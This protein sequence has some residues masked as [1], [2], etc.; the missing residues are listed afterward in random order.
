[1]K[2]I[3]KICKKEKADISPKFVGNELVDP[4][5]P[6]TQKQLISRI[7]LMCISCYNE[8]KEGK[9]KIAA[10]N[11]VSILQYYNPKSR[12]ND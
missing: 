3:C 1:M 10:N 4:Q 8:Y 5:P 7:L 12:K 6:F 2:D 11:D 9:I